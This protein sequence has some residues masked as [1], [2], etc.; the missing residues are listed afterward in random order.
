MYKV[1]KKNFSN[2]ARKFAH[3]IMHP[4]FPPR[5]IFQNS[6]T[7][8]FSRVKKNIGKYFVSHSFSLV[9]W[10][11]VRKLFNNF[12]WEHLER[13]HQW[14]MSQIKKSKKV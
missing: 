9:I 14:E 13:R 4:E 2:R 1:R 8:D 3:N 6:T 10:T 11:K 5:Q 7:Q 12:S